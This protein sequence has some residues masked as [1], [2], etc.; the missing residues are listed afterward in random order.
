VKNLLIQGYNIGVWG[1]QCP[2]EGPGCWKLLVKTALKS[3]ILPSMFE[4]GVEKHRTFATYIH[5][6]RVQTVGVLFHKEMYLTENGLI[7][8]WTL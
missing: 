1:Y 3:A 2:Q 6:S 5:F 7:T 8:P 4:Q